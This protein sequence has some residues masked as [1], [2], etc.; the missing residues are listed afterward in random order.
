MTSEDARRLL[1]MWRRK[2]FDPDNMIRDHHS[3]VPEL[4]PDGGTY[5]ALTE[6]GKIIQAEMF[7]Q[8][9]VNRMIEEAAYFANDE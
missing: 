2:G 7:R 4:L 8:Q 1:E 3:H 5:R 9:D 6:A